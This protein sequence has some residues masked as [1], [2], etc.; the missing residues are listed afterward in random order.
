ME[1]RRLGRIGR[2][3]SVL[4]FGGAAL[5]EATEEAS[6][7]AIRQALDAGVDHFDTAADYGDSELQYGRWMPEIRDRIFLSTKTGDREKDAARRSIERSL[8][9]LRVDSV[10]LI[11]LHAVCDLEDLDRATGP[12]GALEAAIEAKEEGLVGAVGITGHGHE[13]PAVHLEALRRYP[14]ETVLT[15][16]N[17]ILS[18]DE[19]Y[20]RD[21]E[22]LVDEIKRQDAGLMTIK[23]ISRRNWPEGDPT[24]DQRY[25]TWY[26]PFDR[27]E[28][29]DAAVSFVLSYEEITGIAMVGD[30]T[31]VPNMLESI[32]REMPREEAERVLAQA[33]DYSSPFI[34]VPF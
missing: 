5:G 28:H 9:R 31:L 25:T 33:P 19:D 1:H 20:R 30:V 2:E 15:P 3:N 29:I 12:G 23:T 21:F 34:S 32:G 18:T 27:Q 6:D 11:Q 13:A 14:F 8:E 26:E 7:L 17:F 10:D 4:I 22:A 16:W 24:G